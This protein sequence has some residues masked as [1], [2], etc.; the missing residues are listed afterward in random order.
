M[1]AASLHVLRSTVPTSEAMGQG[2]P[3]GGVGCPSSLG[4]HTGTMAQMIKLE[5]VPRNSG[6]AV[7]GGLPTAVAGAVAVREE[8]GRRGS[9]ERQPQRTAERE[10][11]QL[12]VSP[13]CI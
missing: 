1:G 13:S 10:Q 5:Q 3:S 12:P 9:G 4:T 2:H 8:Q 6:V 7:G 11:M